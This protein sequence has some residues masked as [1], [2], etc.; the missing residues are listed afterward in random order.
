MMHSPA[1]LKSMTME[2]LEDHSVE[3]DRYAKKVRDEMMIRIV[4]RDVVQ[5]AEHGWSV[6]EAHPYA[7]KYYLRW[8]KE[9]AKRLRQLTRGLVK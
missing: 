6:E 5:D 1:T 8:Y 4:A 3:A 9:S 7:N 2:E